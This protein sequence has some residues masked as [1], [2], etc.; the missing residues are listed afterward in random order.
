MRVADYSYDSTR[1]ARLRSEDLIVG[2]HHLLRLATCE[3]ERAR[4]LRIL[5]VGETGSGKT[6]F[7]R[8][9]N[10]LL[11]RHAGRKR[12]FEQINCA[13]LNPEHFQDIMFGHKR[14]AFTG[15]VSDKSGLVEL[16][17]GGDLFLD[18]IG[19]MPLSTQ[20]HLLTFLD[21]MEYYRLGDDQKRTADVRILSATNCNL[22]ELV[23][24]GR[25]RKDLYSRLSQVVV[26]LPPLRQ[27]MSDLPLLL[28]Y[29]V[30][31]F[32]GFHK[33]CDPKLVSILQK[34]PW[35]EGNVREFRDAVEYL[36]LMSEGCERLEVSHLG[37]RYIGQPEPAE[38]APHRAALA[39]ERVYEWGLEGYL[40][41]LE[42]Q[43]LEDLLKRRP[44][45]LNQLARDLKI[46]RSTLYRRI[47][48]LHLEKCLAPEA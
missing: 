47:K 10:R 11:E 27:R 34:H 7:A 31:K 2:E 37:N 30:H 9:S 19:D 33:P 15:A 46:S 43:L 1:A 36:C 45:G 32:T 17:R 6:P 26:N 16:A 21:T 18:E 48:Q 14:G 13:C 5:F 3:T 40:A 44:S 39:I 25:F 4:G 20:S 22:G 42:S 28:R 41:K 12:P 35:N 23:R 38:E 29:F 8:Y 24:A